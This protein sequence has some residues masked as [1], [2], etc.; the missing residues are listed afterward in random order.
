MS[1]A[2]V[3]LSRRFLARAGLL[4]LLGGIPS[5]SSL[6]SDAPDAGALVVSISA[7]RHLHLFGYTFFCKKKTVEPD[8]VGRD[9]EKFGYAEEDWSTKTDFEDA[10]KT[11][12]V[13]YQRFAP[14]EYDIYSFMVPRSAPFANSYFHPTKPFSIPFTIRPKDT[15]YIGNFDAHEITGG[16][17]LGLST[18]AGVYFV[19]S[20]Q[21]D[22]DIPIAQKQNA[23]VGTVRKEVPDPVLLGI[24]LLFRRS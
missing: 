22:R 2:T 1:S 15:T 19:L 10:E 21:G 17:T 24:P 13:R 23:I 9:F 8:L 16:H 3:P 7:A 6:G 12:V 14:G 4:P 18:A 11:G 5:C 20:D